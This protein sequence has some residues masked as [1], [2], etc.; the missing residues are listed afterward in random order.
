MGHEW[1]IYTIEEKY[2]AE[3]CNIPIREVDNL[4]YVEYL[5]Y[6]RD[7]RIYRLSQT[8]EGQQYLKNAW[9]IKQVE[10]ERSKLREQFNKKNGGAP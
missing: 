2:V 1:Y 3:Y 10:P 8:Q 7:A 5:C 6:L 9:R 4:D